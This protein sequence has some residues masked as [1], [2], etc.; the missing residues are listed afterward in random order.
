M[1]HF[2]DRTGLPYQGP[3]RRKGADRR[4]GNDRR[5]DI[6][7]ELDKDDRRNGRDRRRSVGGWD[8]AH[9]R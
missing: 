2:E 4:V 8:Q 1:L 6:R 5:R 3:D 9:S 7:F